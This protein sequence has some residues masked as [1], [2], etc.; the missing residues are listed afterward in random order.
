MFEQG[1]RKIE[2]SGKEPQ[3]DGIRIDPASH[4]YRASIVDIEIEAAPT[5]RKVTSNHRETQQ[6]DRPNQV[7]SD[8]HRIVVSGPQDFVRHADDDGVSDPKNPYD[9]LRPPFR[10]ELQGR[11]PGE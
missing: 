11:E 4:C 9:L 1:R 10:S 2:L 6:P 5:A 3:V 8:S 7:N